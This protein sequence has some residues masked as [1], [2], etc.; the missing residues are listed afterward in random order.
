MSEP[1]IIEALQNQQHAKW[2][3]QSEMGAFS[4]EAVYI[5]NLDHG[6]TSPSLDPSYGGQDDPNE[7]IINDLDGFRGLVEKRNRLQKEIAK[8]KPTAPFFQDKR[9]ALEGTIAK[10]R[11]NQDDLLAMAQSKIDE[12]G[13]QIGLQKDQRERMDQAYNNVLAELN[14]PENN[15][16]GTPSGGIQP[17]NKK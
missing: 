15:Q 2:K 1:N 12:L 11:E 16:T 6:F 10:I 7:R 9:N 5:E 4:D 3:A 17:T 13:E 8:L 14:K